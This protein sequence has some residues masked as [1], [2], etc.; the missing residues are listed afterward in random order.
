MKK[1]FLLL[2]LIP[3]SFNAQL[4]LKN[5]LA[6]H[7]IKSDYIEDYLSNAL[8][9]KKVKSEQTISSNDYEYYNGKDILSDGIYI[10]VMIPL[11]DEYDNIVAIQCANESDVKELKA[12]LISNG[13]EYTGKKELKKDYNMYTYA[14]KNTIV[15]ISENKNKTGLYEINMVPKIK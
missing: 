13:F 9:F 1:L 14:K 3:L 4:R 6:L 11:I 15:G 10:K 5:I 8:G 12:E 7:I 2:F